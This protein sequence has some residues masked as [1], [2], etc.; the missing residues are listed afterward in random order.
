MGHRKASKNRKGRSNH[1]K[2]DHRYP[3]HLHPQ[4]R[5]SDEQ[6]SRRDTGLGRAED[7]TTPK[8]QT[9]KPTGAALFLHRP[10]KRFL[11]STEA[12]I[13]RRRHQKELQQE[14]KRIQEELEDHGLDGEWTHVCKGGRKRTVSVGSTMANHRDVTTTWAQRAGSEQST[15]PPLDDPIAFPSLS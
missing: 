11:P 2:N 8:R 15:P 3:H 4:P 1:H 7:L 13:G 6:A 9:L 5:K 14:V 12:A 10:S